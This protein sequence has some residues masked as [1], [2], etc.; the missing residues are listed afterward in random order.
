M[1]S[2]NLGALLFAV[3]VCTPLSIVHIGLE[4]W[5]LL[6]KLKLQEEGLMA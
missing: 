3:G 2:T 5:K 6:F 4:W 1:L